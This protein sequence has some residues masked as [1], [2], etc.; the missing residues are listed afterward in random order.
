MKRDLLGQA[1]GA[2]RHDMRKTLLTMLG[3]AWGIATVVLLLA[4]GKASL[5]QSRI[6]GRLRSY[7]YRHFSWAHVA[8]GRAEIK[9]ESQIRFTHEDVELIRNVV[10]LVRHVSRAFANF[11]PRYRTA[12]VHSAFQCSEWILQWKT[13]G[14]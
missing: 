14:P 13:S 6:S 11:K 1:Y 7:G 3:M 12:T 8:A 5:A 10:P 2:M 4:Y 9:P